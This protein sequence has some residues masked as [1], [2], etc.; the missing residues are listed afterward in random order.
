MCSLDLKNY[1]IKK[2]SKKKV[3]NILY[4]LDSIKKSNNFTRFYNC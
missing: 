2:E 3:K 1:G 4:R